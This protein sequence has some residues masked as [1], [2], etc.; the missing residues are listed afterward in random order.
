[1]PTNYRAES[2]SDFSLRNDAVVFSRDLFAGEYFLPPRPGLWFYNPHQQ[3]VWIYEAAG[4]RS[5]Y[6]FTCPDFSDA[7]PEQN[8]VNYQKNQWDWR[9]IPVEVPA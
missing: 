2:Y 7:W 5:F 9:E 6:K 8:Q 1:M 3:H 4:W